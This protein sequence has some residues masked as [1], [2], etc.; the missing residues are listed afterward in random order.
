[1]KPA[2]ATIAAPTRLEQRAERRGAILDATVRILGT[3]GLGAVTH[4]AVAREAGVPLAA[5]TYY[6]SSKDE[7]V[8]EALRLLVEDEIARIGARAA[9][10][11]DDL[12][13][14][15]RTAAAL[16][17]V[18]LPGRGAARALLAKFEVY[19]EAARRPALRQT[20]AHW[21]GA[22]TALAES[23]LKGVGAPDPARRAQLLVA[24]VDGILVHELASGGEDADPERLRPRL[25]QLFELI[26]SD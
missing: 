12:A 21:R 25:E 5:T 15:D 18:L 23:A 3:R 11:G 7:L 14:P 1:V 20:A 16:A 4:R 6:F 26:L 10:L 22:L 13:S 17:A 24:A 8:T 19:L 2:P 9:E